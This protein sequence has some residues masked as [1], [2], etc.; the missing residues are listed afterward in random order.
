MGDTVRCIV[1]IEVDYDVKLTIDD[2]VGN[3][4]KDNV[5]DT[6]INIVRI[7]VDDDVKLT[8][9]DACIYNAGLIVG[10]IVDTSF[11]LY[12]RKCRNTVTD[13]VSDDIGQIV[14]IVIRDT[15]GII[16]GIIVGNNVSK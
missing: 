2:T 8:I 11:V 16:D 10:L 5:G 7:E 3:D 4:V 9:D 6:V 14:S 13:T 1:G 15:V 12:W